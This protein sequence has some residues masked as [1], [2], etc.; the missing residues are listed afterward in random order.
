MPNE[1]IEQIITIDT[2]RQFRT[3]K[4]LCARSD[5]EEAEEEKGRKKTF[6]QVKIRALE[7]LSMDYVEG[8]GERDFFLFFCCFCSL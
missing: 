4:P 6:N 3:Q 7:C 1:A 2:R 5:S 8:E